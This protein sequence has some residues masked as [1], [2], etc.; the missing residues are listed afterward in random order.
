MSEIS[1][2]CP[3]CD[4]EYRLPEAAIPPAGREV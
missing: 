2:I 4:A 1:L 3:A